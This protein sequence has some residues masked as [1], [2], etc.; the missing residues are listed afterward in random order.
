MSNRAAAAPDLP[1]RPVAAAPASDA[2]APAGLPGRKTQEDIVVDQT[3]S[4]A[5][6]AA[7]ISAFKNGASVSAVASMLG[8]TPGSVEWLLK[9]NG[10]KK[11]AYA[12]QMGSALTQRK[13]LDHLG[14]VMTDT[15][16]QGIQFGQRFDA[17]DNL[18]LY[19]ADQPTPSGVVWTEYDEPMMEVP[20]EWSTDARLCLLA[21]APGPCTVSGVVMGMTTHERG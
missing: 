5:E 19:E 7:A 3:C 14:L 16:Y 18:P 13:R 8:K 1:A 21:Q 12:A 20:G 4:P 10:L 11:L 15:H 6:Q 17:L 9:K 2:A